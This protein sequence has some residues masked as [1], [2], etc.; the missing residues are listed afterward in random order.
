MDR[1]T[2]V[3][4]LTVELDKLQKYPCRVCNLETQHKTVACLTENGSEDC[5]GGHGVD[6]S[7]DNQIIQCLGCEEVSFRVRSTN[8]EDYD[9]EYDIGHRFYHEI[10]TLSR[11]RHR[12]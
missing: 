12:G 7:E 1:I 2:K 10:I 11:A 6:W 5:G 9:H 3:S 4:V 8:S